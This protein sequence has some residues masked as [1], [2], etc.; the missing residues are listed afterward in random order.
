MRTQTS[1]LVIVD[2]GVEELPTEECITL[3]LRELG[4]V[5]TLMPVLRYRRPETVNDRLRHLPIEEELRGH[6]KRHAE[7]AGTLPVS[8]DGD[9]LR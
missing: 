9:R 6:V 8:R 5:S 1:G 4:Q 3:W 2:V 7:L